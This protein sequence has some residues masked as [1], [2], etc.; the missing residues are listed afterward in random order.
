MLLDIAEQLDSL[1]TLSPQPKGSAPE[2]GDKHGTKDET[3]KK[4]KLGNTEDTPKKQ[5]SHEKS[6][7]R[8]SPTE[9][10]LATLSH[11]HNVNLEANKLG[12]GFP[13]LSLCCQ[14]NE[15]SG[16]YPQLKGSRSPPHE[17]AA[18]ES[19]C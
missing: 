8:Q 3:P 9:K 17:A 10:S 7:L 14:D 13:S 19:L 11:E 18:R 6:Q 1:R 16:G 2:L 12:T 4:G 15:G 5:K